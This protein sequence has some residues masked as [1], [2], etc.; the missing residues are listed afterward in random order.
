MKHGFS[1]W[2]QG[3]TVPALTECAED[4]ADDGQVS[5]AKW[6]AIIEDTDNADFLRFCG[7]RLSGSGVQARQCRALAAAALCAPET[8]RLWL[9]GA[10]HPCWQNMLAVFL[11]TRLTYPDDAAMRRAFAGSEGGAA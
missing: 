5:L 6:A 1:A 2:N 3:G 11:A 4:A 10:S 7:A 9:S 8:A